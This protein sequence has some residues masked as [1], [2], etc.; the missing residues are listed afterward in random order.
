MAVLT[1]RDLG[2]LL[3]AVPAA[4]LVSRPARGDEPTDEAR[5]IADHEAGLSAEERERVLKGLEDQEKSLKVVRDYPLGNDVAPAFGFRPLHSK[6][7]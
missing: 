4:G 5:F 7:R 2:K 3:I 6:R 1:R